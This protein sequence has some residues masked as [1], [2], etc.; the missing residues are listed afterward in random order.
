MRGGLF[1]DTGAWYAVQVP[2]DRWHEQAVSTLKRAVAQGAP[3]L[4]TN[5]VMGETYTLLM[6]THGHA[7]CRRFLDTL[8][9]SARL[10]TVHVDGA[11]EDEAWKLIERFHDQEFSFVD[12]TSFALMRKKRVHQAF[13]FDRHFAT[14][15]FVRVPLDAPVP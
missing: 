11:T 4:T 15:G 8:A 12:A 3:L 7:A 2:G 1:V 10:E 6:R 9:R 14:A 5:H 13:A